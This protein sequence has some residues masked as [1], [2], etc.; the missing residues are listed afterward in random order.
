MTVPSSVLE[1]A[2]TTLPGAPL[3]RRSHTIPLNIDVPKGVNVS[4]LSKVRLYQLFQLAQHLL[5]LEPQMVDGGDLLEPF[6]GVFGITAICLFDAATDAYYA[7]GSL[8]Q[9]WE[10]RTRAACVTGKDADEAG[11]TIRCLSVGGRIAGAIAFQ[12]LEDPEQTTGPLLSLITALHERTRVRRKLG[13]EFKN[14]LTA[15]LT[16]AGGLREAGPLTAAQSE[17]ARMVEEEASRL[18]GVISWVDRIARM[19]QEGGHH[20]TADEEFDSEEP[21]GKS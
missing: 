14:G 2:A 21:Q 5:V 3:L 7:R 11:V 10:G 16:A 4:R 15:I 20:G 12:G 17:M 13:D 1:I 18:A 9:E 8:A 6:Q 19:D